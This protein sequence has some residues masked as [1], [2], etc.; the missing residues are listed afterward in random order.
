MLRS[1]F[2][3]R[4]GAPFPSGRRSWPWNSFS[5]YKSGI[6]PACVLCHD[7]VAPNPSLFERSPSSA[8]ICRPQRRDGFLIEQNGANMLI[9]TPLRRHSIM[10]IY[11]PHNSIVLS[12]GQGLK[13]RLSVSVGTPVRVRTLSEFRQMLYNPTIAPG[14]AF[15]AIVSVWQSRMV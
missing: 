8:T 15:Q 11:S 1:S 6:L 9:S 13:G 3:R 12:L 5:H 14:P 4:Q 2:V 7:D 10:F